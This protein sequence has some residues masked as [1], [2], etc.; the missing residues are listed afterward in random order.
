MKTECSPFGSMSFT[1]LCTS[2]GMGLKRCRLSTVADSAFGRSAS[3]ASSSV[4]STPHESAPSTSLGGADER[5][6]KRASPS[7]EQR[8]LSEADVLRSELA[9]GDEAFVMPGSSADV[10][11]SQPPTAYAYSAQSAAGVMSLKPSEGP[12]K[13][14]RATA[15]V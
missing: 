10:A 3:S 1:D 13:R 5:M 4:S 12:R 6:A 11:T 8:K 9:L 7:A 14:L 2:L 15:D